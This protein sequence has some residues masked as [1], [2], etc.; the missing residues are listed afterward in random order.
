[1]PKKV[2]GS[3]WKHSKKHKKR[4]YIGCYVYVSGQRE[5]RLTTILKNGKADWVSFES[6]QA[7]KALGW[8]LL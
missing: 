1:M 4:E 5:F 6:P 7:A 3:T 2:R 8:R